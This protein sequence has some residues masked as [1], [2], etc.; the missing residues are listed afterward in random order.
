L[1]SDKPASVLRETDEQARRLAR[2]LLR[3][4][5]YAAMAV[6]DP[7]RGFPVASRVL[8]GTDVD[9]VPVILVSALSAHTKAL[10]GDPRA[11]LLAGEP[12][13]GDPLAHPRLSV[14]CI[15]EAVSHDTAAHVRI[16]GRFLARH[17]KAKLYV[18]FADFQFFRLQPQ[19]ANLNGG[20]GKAFRLTGEDLVIRSDLTPFIADRSESLVQ[21]LLG[22]YPLLPAR[23]AGE[24]KI[25]TTPKWRIYA[26]DAAGFDLI[27]GNRLLRHEFQEPLN[28]PKDLELLIAKIANPVP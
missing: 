18:D 4:A 17:A 13:K 7:E 23:L 2:I 1:A 25:G 26:M 22:T 14:E 3:S 12:G 27:S 21:D 8:V 10:A 5:P 24:E 28:N 16:R 9:G 20:F 15:A 19:A 11:S 6:I